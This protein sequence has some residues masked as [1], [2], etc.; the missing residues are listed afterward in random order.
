M[1]VD[2]HIITINAKFEKHPFRIVSPINEWNFSGSWQ[3]VRSIRGHPFPLGRKIC[4]SAQICVPRN[5]LS[6][7][8]CISAL[9]KLTENTLC[10]T[11]NNFFAYGAEHVCSTHKLG[12]Y[13]SF[14]LK[15]WMSQNFEICCATLHPFWEETSSVFTNSIWWLELA[16]SK[17]FINRTRSCF[18]AE[19]LPIDFFVFKKHI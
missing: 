8:I 7:K 14:L 17:P 3:R 1:L 4:I 16:H 11:R 19:Y 10:L 15:Y 12:T 9:S 13:I 2:H 6:Q 18:N 5:N